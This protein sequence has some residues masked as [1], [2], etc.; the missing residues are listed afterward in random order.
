MFDLIWNGL[1]DTVSL[2][3][4]RRTVEDER[5]RLIIMAK[6]SMVTMSFVVKDWFNGGLAGRGRVSELPRQ[7]KCFGRTGTLRSLY[8]VEV[9]N[10][11][12]NGSEKNTDHFV[13]SGI[14][15]AGRNA[16]TSQT[17]V[18]DENG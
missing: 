12:Y 1:L 5:K 14:D 6:Y 16:K 10:G 11:A 7:S 3:F 13:P 15:G 18:R 4:T 17:L 9:R 2:A 8:R